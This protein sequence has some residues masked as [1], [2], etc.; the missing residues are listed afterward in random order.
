MPTNPHPIAQTDT[1]T[2]K[3]EHS[4]FEYCTIS[5]GKRQ[6]LHEQRPLE[7]VKNG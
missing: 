5:I 4:N 1:A 2:D 3:K 7:C 6:N